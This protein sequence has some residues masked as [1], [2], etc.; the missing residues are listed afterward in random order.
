MKKWI[1]L[2][3][4]TLLCTSVSGC[5]VTSVVSGVVGTAVDVVDAVT[6]DIV[7]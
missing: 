4:L 7:D 3:G 2:L 5:L 1:K 6:P